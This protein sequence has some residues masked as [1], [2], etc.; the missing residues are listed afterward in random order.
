MKGHAGYVINGRIFIEF[1]GEKVEFKAG[2]GLFIPGGE[3]DRHRGS[4]PEGEKAL[5]VMFEKI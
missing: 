4:V 5:L 1:D 3:A 2:D